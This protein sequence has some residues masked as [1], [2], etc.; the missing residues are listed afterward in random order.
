MLHGDIREKAQGDTESIIQAAI[1]L[2]DYL[3][4]TSVT[5]SAI[6]RS[7]AKDSDILK[8]VTITKTPMETYLYDEGDFVE[9]VEDLGTVQDLLSER[10]P[11]ADTVEPSYE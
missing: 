8:S 3:E 4:T 6:N 5:V 1:Q 2:L 7:A 11:T 9:N 10:M